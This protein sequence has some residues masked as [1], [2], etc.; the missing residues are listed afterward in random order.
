MGEGSRYIQG[1]MRVSY[2]EQLQLQRNKEVG[3]GRFIAFL[4]DW[5]I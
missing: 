1:V 5:L 2:G 4:K 3:S